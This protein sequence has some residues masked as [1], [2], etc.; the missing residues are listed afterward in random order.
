[1]YPVRPQ[2]PRMS[3]ALSAGATVLLLAGASAMPA[4]LL[5]QSFQVGTSQGGLWVV[6]TDK[7]VQTPSS[8]T[9]TKSTPSIEPAVSE[10]DSVAADSTEQK[11]VTIDAQLVPA[12]K[13]RKTGN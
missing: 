3:L 6:G 2:S 13:P 4:P 8:D 10:D 11:P 9:T 5:A 1:M 7:V 12:E